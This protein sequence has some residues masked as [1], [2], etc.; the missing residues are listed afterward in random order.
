MKCEDCRMYTSKSPHGGT[1]DRTSMPVDGDSPNCRHFKLSTYIHK[2]VV[3]NHKC[4]DCLGFKRLSTTTG[5]CEP[6]GIK[7]RGDMIRCNDYVRVM[8]KFEEEDYWVV[9]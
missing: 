7:V 2:K 4:Y 9:M 3:K 6:K 8:R 5:L 1:C